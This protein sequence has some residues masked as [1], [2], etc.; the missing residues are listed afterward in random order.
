[1]DKRIYICAA[2]IFILAVLGLLA[3]NYLEIV[4]DKRYVN[5]AEESYRNSFLAMERWLTGEGYPVSYDDYLYSSELSEQPEKVIIYNSREYYDLQM[6]FVLEWIEQGSFFVLCL[7]RNYENNNETKEIFELLY[8]YGIKVDFRY[9]HR[10]NRSYGFPD[11]ADTTSF[12]LENTTVTSIKT[13]KDSDGTIRLVE[14]PI[15]KGALTVTGAPVFMYSRNLNKD[16]NAALTWSLTGERADGNGILIIRDYYRN[17]PRNQL[18]GTL[19][20]NGNLAPVGISALLLIVIG[21]WMVI[22]LFGQVFPDKKTAVR[23]ITDRFNAEVRFLK[24]NRAL[25]HYLKIYERENKTGEQ[26]DANIEYNY[27]ELINKYRR[28]FYEKEKN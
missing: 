11:F 16:A 23:P 27:R 6:D 22:P 9:I 1:M 13:I 7:Y 3:Y 5:E 25:D 8:E 4:P 14:I 20:E 15:G 18:F 21:F 12:E 26:S 2:I 19:I 10:E 28:I 17:S 24:K